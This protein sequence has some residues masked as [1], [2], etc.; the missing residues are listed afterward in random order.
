[1]IFINRFY[2]LVWKVYMKIMYYNIVRWCDN[3]YMDKILI[4]YWYNIVE[5]IIYWEERVKKKKVL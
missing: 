2:N 1:M 4:L 3:K 5:K